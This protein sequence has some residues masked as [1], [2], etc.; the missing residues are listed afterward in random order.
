[1]TIPI[2]LSAERAS[3]LLEAVDNALSLPIAEVYRALSLILSSILT[4]ATQDANIL[5][6][7]PFARM[8]Y[9][10]REINYSQTN[11]AYLNATR[12][13]LRRANELTAEEQQRTIA[14][15]ALCIAEFITALCQI[16]LPHELNEK[17]PRQHIPLEQHHAFSE[18]AR[19]VVTRWDNDIAYGEIDSIGNAALRYN[20]TNRFGTWGYL[21][22]LLFKG[23]QL[24]LARP[25]RGNDGTISADLIICLPDLLINITDITRCIHPTCTSYLWYLKSLLTS[26]PSSGPILLGNFSGHLLDARLHQKDGEP[27]NYR[28]SVQRFFQHNALKI[29]QQ[30]N[31]MN[32]FHTQGRT[33]LANIDSIVSNQLPNLQGYNL[34]K[35]VLEPTL[36]CD[37]LGLQGRTDLL[38]NDYRVLIEQKS[39]KCDEWRSQQYPE[40]SLQYKTDHFAQL[41]LYQAML[42]YGL[43]V[44][45]D[46]VSSAL[47]YSKYPNGLIRTGTAPTLLGLCIEIRNRIARLDYALAN[48]DVESIFNRITADSFNPN[49]SASTLWTKYTRPEVEAFVST[50]RSASPL[51]LSYFYRFVA[52]I[53]RERLFGR[54]GA[55]QRQIDGFASIWC[56]SLPEKQEAGSILHDLSVGSL[57]STA[58][59]N[60]VAKIAFRIPQRLY[61]SNTNFRVGDIV[62]LHEYSA[63]AVPNATAGMTFRGT[64]ENL[65]PQQI[66]VTLRAPQR[67]VALFTDS[68]ARRWAIEHDRYDSS[69]KLQLQSLF[70]LLSTTADR[71]NL[72]LS[73]RPPRTD[74]ARTLLLD[75]TLPNGNKEFNELALRAKRARDFFLVV[76]PPGTG[77]T[78]FGLMCILREELATPGTNV[79]LLSF[80]NRAV[81]EICSKLE[82]DGVSYLRVGSLLG[83]G[84]SYRQRLL[85]EA[86]KGCRNVDSVTDL[87]TQTRVFTSTTA[88]LLNAPE[89]LQLKSFS[90]A[91]ID[92]ASQ[93]LEP[94]LLGLL[95]AQ[96]NGA[97]S[98]QRFVLIGDHR[99]LPAV[100]MQPKGD[101]S[102]TEPSLRA[103]GLNDCRE[104][105][106]ERLYRLHRRNPQIV[107]QLTRQGRMHPNVADFANR[108]FYGGQLKPIPQPHQ[109]A[110]LQLLSPSSSPLHSLLCTHRTLFF[111]VP[112]IRDNSHTRNGKSNPAE[113]SAIASIIKAVIEIYQHCRK[114]FTPTQ[115]IGVIVPYRNQITQVRLALRGI[116]S[117]NIP[118]DTLEAIAVDTVERYQGS[119]RD[120]IIYGLTVQHLFQLSFL[121]DSRTS[122]EDQLVDRKL[123][124]ALT[125][126]REQM[127]IVGNAALARHDEL[128]ARLVEDYGSRG[129]V[130]EWDKLAGSRTA[131]Q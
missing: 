80:T 5:F 97:P 107:Y 92:E 109:T 93:I 84:E 43:H 77:K 33:Q 14:E 55:P 42:R 81:D 59:D 40:G 44:P 22:Q 47:L 7:S 95:C 111:N 128:Y 101:S 114:P 27:T 61:D 49:G 88:S 74:S 130:V 124:V 10:C 86:A 131:K 35:V 52:F 115:H 99:Q 113:A 24:S 76:G 25:T 60:G 2:N 126:A 48:E 119:E 26:S 106:F 91:I 9:L 23:M 85:R 118:S 120:I 54:T 18:S 78:S 89:L 37:A 100:V 94:N 53:S 108:L 65:S 36:F 90:L 57:S 29:A 110:P 41:L 82:K 28:Q 32:G 20:I 38:Q 103:I 13:R 122:I 56:A 125:R 45:N 96:R 104:S 69:E 75:H 73:D 105:L 116:A 63:N 12:D 64:I 1:M 66:T 4:E 71:R 121:T 123:N 3:T 6:N 51:A 72:L 112:S 68:P 11:R 8:D 17:L 16:P 127:I 30:R 98:I 62:V 15:N 58:E 39:G 70:S 117:S 129:E 21:N 46:K 50:L 79:L 87:I 67:N 31:A 34:E 19:M 102:V 83:C